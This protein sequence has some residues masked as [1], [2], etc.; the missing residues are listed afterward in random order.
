MKRSKMCSGRGF[1]SRQVHHK[2]IKMVRY[3]SSKDRSEEFGW[4]KVCD[5]HVPTDEEQRFW[6][7]AMII[8]ALAFAGLT[9][10]FL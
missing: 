2:E 8:F 4:K 1:D 9:L 3:D 10:I 5:E 7:N 6:G